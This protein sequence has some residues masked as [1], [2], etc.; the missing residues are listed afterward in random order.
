[1]RVRVVRNSSGIALLPKRLA[2]FEVDAT[3][4]DQWGRRCAGYSTTTA[5]EG[6]PI[7]EY[8]PAA[9]VVDN[10]LFYVIMDGP[11]VVLTSLSDLAADAAAGDWFVSI[12]GAT[13]Q[14]TTSGRLSLTTLVTTNS[15][16]A[17][18]F[19]QVVNRIGRALSAATTQN[20]NFDVLVEVG[21]W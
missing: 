14:A 15:T 17:A 5:A 16:G 8:L 20:T 18:L 7:D 1:M 10:D 6:H 3:D 11:A 2:S 12:T 21:R 13:S 19:N 9:G 4:P